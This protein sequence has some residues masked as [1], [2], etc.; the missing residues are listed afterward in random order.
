MR[1]VT[2]IGKI[3]NNTEIKMA[4]D[5]EIMEYTIDNLKVKSFGKAAQTAKSFSG[6]VVGTGEIKNR[7]YTN[8]EG[9]TFNIQEIIINKIEQLE[10]Q[11]KDNF[12][13]TPQSIDKWESGKNIEIDKDELPFY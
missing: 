13:V 8:K 2:I 6:I 1:I 9:K 12:E 7:D 3:E 11:Q 10:E 5:L 4:K